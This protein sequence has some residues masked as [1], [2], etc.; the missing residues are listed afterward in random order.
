MVIMLIACEIVNR[1][2]FRFTLDPHTLNS[3]AVIS[4]QI[5]KLC[6]CFMSFSARKNS[7]ENNYVYM[8]F[9]VFIDH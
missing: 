1:Y 2:R 8:P 7:L 6:L 5:G 9:C 3:L 4:L